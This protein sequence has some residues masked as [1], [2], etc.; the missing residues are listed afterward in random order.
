M[1]CFD[2]ECFDTYMYNYIGSLNEKDLDEIFTKHDKDGKTLN[3]IKTFFF[4]MLEYTASGIFSA[5]IHEV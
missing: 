1:A 3:D 4:A 2:K 5:N